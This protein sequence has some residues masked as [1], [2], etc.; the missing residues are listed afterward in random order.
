MYV[1]AQFMHLYLRITDYKDSHKHAN[2]Q[3]GIRHTE[4]KGTKRHEYLKITAILL[5]NNFNT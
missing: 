1:S 5:T 2:E 4:D 3:Q